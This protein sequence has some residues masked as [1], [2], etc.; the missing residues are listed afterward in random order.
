MYKS[1]ALSATYLI[2]LIIVKIKILWGYQFLWPRIFRLTEQFIPES[3]GYFNPMFYFDDFFVVSLL[4]V[5]FTYAFKKNNR[6]INGVVYLIYLVICVFSILSSI[7]FYKYEVPLNLA[8]INQIDN[9]YTMRTS[10]DTEMMENYRLIAAF[11]LLLIF[12]VLF[13]VL[14]IF[15]K[16][17][18]SKNYGSVTDATVRI[19]W[20]VISFLFF[21][22]LFIIKSYYFGMDILTETPLTTLS[23]SFVVSLRSNLTVN[24]E[25]IPEF[26]DQITTTSK[27]I[28]GKGSDILAKY[29]GKYNVILIILETTNADFFCPKGPFS[30]YLPNLSKLGKEGLYLPRFFTPF[31]RSSKAFF[32]IITGCYPLTSYKS[33]IKVAPQIKVPSIFSILKENGYSTFAGYS[34]DFNYDRMADFLEKRGVDRFVDINNNDGRYNQTSWCADDELIYDQLMTW[35]NSLD[36]HAPFFAFLLPMNTHHPFWTPKKDLKVVPEHDQKGRYINAIHYQDYL[37]GELIDFLDR[38]NKLH[39]TM[40]II[41]G[42]HGAVFNFLKP[43]G[44]KVSPYIIDKD[45]VQVPFFLYLPFIRLTNIECDVVGSHVDILPTILDTL[46]IDIEEKVQ[47]RSIFDPRIRDRISFIYSDYYRH[48][49]AGLTNNGY[50]MRDMTEDTTVLSRTLD[51]TKNACDDE[52]EMCTLLKRKVEEFDKFQNQRLLRHC[53]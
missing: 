4:F 9:L 34:G 6:R 48:I 16:R 24:T 46:G 5:T 47:G 7:A 12:S 19:R 50:L 53:R 15:F 3:I 29:R 44:T 36:S 42:D 52:K 11:S 25:K 8:V 38:A 33:I 32:A 23:K 14:L 26:Y 51:F 31:P 40:V 1:V 35:I 43:E 13:P 41:T 28:E 45:T 10:I 17:L 22:G 27:G 2:L 20:L 37:V 49:I 39:N 30:Q 18:L 21:F